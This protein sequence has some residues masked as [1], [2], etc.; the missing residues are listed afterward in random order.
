MPPHHRRKSNE[1]DVGLV[2]GSGL[3]VGLEVGVLQFCGFGFGRPY[4]MCS[5]RSWN[6]ASFST[7][8]WVVDLVDDSH[9]PGTC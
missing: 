4:N 8:F 9:E 7:L 3:E 5:P 1:A 6:L 2:T